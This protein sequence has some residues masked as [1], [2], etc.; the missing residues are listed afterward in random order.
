MIRSARFAAA[1]L[2]LAAG[3]LPALAEEPNIE[4]SLELGMELRVF[5]GDPA[6]GSQQ[7]RAAS[8]SFYLEPEI[9]ADWNGGDDRFTLVPYARVD[10][11]DDSRTHVDL[12]EAN[13]LH[14]GDGYDLVVGAD[15]VFWGVT[16][17][18][19]LV[20]IVNQSDGVEDVDG[21]DKLG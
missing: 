7:D 16:E 9:T 3:A 17:S 2:C 1:G 10:Q 13:W 19:H 15:K 4:T 14:F 12:R 20:D 8:P 18:R 11:D 5:P 6:F 21:E